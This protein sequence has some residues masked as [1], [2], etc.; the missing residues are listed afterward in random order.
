MAYHEAVQMGHDLT[1]RMNRTEGDNPSDESVTNSSSDDSSDDGGAVDT[2]RLAGKLNKALAANEDEDTQID[3]KFKKLFA[4]DFMKNAKLRQQDKAREEAA[5]LLRE[6][7]EM[8]AGEDSDHGADAEAGGSKNAK[9]DRTADGKSSVDAKRMQDAKTLMEGLYGG[10]SVTAK[11]VAT[12]S[13]SK[14]PISKTASTEELNPWLD[15]VAGIDRVLDK[16]GGSKKRKADEIR[17]SVPALSEVITA[18]TVSSKEAAN[19]VAPASA[20]P[21][22]SSS[23]KSVKMASSAPAKATSTGVVAA[24]SLPKLTVSVEKSV[25]KAAPEADTA[26]KAKKQV[27]VERSQEDLVRE[28]FAGPDLE[29]EFAAMKRETVDNE[30]DI[31][32]KKQKI[33]SQ[34]TRIN[35]ILIR[36]L[37]K[38]A[39]EES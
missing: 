18:A 30:L 28:A 21:N 23:A 4:M 34:G 14:A 15:S 11:A 17:V 13:S 20:S 19:N 5:M 16:E 1:K 33:L 27:L 37:Y 29:A 7:A 39:D 26:P 2:E 12:S 31:D 24:P 25:A 3:G 6:I 9:S 32:V 36:Y 10:D 38:E 22:P 35:I 8:D